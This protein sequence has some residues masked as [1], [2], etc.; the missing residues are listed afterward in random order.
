MIAKQTKG[1][2]MN[3]DDDFFADVDVVQEQEDEWVSALLGSEEDLVNYLTKEA[4]F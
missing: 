2:S 4:N 1:E 3:F